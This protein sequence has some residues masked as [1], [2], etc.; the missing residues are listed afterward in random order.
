MWISL[1]WIIVKSIPR[2]LN[3]THGHVCFH[4]STRQKLNI[5]IS[6]WFV[7]E[8][9]INM[10]LRLKICVMWKILLNKNE[11]VLLEKERDLWTIP[12]LLSYKTKVDNYFF[13]GSIFNIHSWRCICTTSIF[14]LLISLVK[15]SIV[16]TSAPNCIYILL[17]KK[18]TC[19]VN[20]INKN[21]KVIW[22]SYFEDKST[23][24]F[25]LQSVKIV[26]N[27]G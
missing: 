20:N 1:F 14:K 12:S 9:T 13:K 17:S 18:F 7:L 8:K 15:I 3:R 10:Y 4:T 6:I 24:T 16:K 23:I 27:R 19:I 21:L 5:Y 2:S 11:N 25:N 26:K 22:Q